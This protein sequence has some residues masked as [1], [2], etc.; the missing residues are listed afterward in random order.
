MN[1]KHLITP[2][3]CTIGFVSASVGGTVRQTTNVQTRTIPGQQQQQQQMHG[4]KTITRTV[5]T[6][7]GDGPEKTSTTRE[8]KTFGGPG[9]ET[10][11][12]VIN[13]GEIRKN[14]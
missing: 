13:T 7:V 10:T 3:R 9:Q 14:V 2:K 1:L 11:S 5:T 4:Q 8:V 6:R 12:A